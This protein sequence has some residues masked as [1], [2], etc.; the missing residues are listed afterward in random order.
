[1]ARRYKVFPIRLLGFSHPKARIIISGGIEERQLWTHMDK[2]FDPV[3]TSIG[4]LSVLIFASLN[5]RVNK[6][7]RELIREI[8]EKIA[9]FSK[10][11]SHE[12]RKKMAFVKF[13][14][15]NS[16]EICRK[17][18]FAKLNSREILFFFCCEISEI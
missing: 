10:Y 18:S 13:A 7:S 4:T 5:F 16:R 1:M 11:N 12:I 17:S 15:L 2:M 3:T 14:K 6:I 8:H 9:K